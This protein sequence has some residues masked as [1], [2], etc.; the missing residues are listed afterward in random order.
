MNSRTMDKELLHSL[1]YLSN[2]CTGSVFDVFVIC[3]IDIG[4]L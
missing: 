1:T 3:V 4:G 2:T